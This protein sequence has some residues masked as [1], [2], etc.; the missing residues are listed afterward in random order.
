M[1]GS[2]YESGRQLTLLKGK[3][4]TSEQKKAATKKPQSKYFY[5]ALA[6]CSQTSPTA[7]ASE[8]ERRH[9]QGSAGTGA[10]PFGSTH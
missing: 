10:I 3:T 9:G 5:I 1:A 8:K 2:V 4:A 7:N 6:F